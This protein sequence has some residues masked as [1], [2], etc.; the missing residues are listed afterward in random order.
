MIEVTKF[1]KGRSS[2]Y[3][4]DTTCDAMEDLYPR[5]R[6]GYNPQM[7]IRGVCCPL[8]YGFQA[9]LVWIGVCILPD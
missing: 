5:G 8:G 4:N 9:D 6:R 1:T 2:F 3:L 7:T